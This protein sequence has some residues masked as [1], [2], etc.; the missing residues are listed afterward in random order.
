MKKTTKNQPP[1]AGRDRRKVFFCLVLFFVSLFLF[2]HQC[3]PLK[4]FEFT[5]VMLVAIALHRCVGLFVSF[6]AALL[7]LCFGDFARRPRD[8]AAARCCCW[9]TDRHSPPAASRSHSQHQLQTRTHTH[10]HAHTSAP[11]PCSA[12]LPAATRTTS[13]RIKSTRAPHQP[14]AAAASRPHAA[15]IPAQLAHCTQRATGKRPLIADCRHSCTRQVVTR[16]HRHEPT[17]HNG[18]AVGVAPAV[19]PLPAVRPAE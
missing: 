11:R 16:D 4:R 8:L 1:W 6:S 2:V 9:L 14:T 12:A 5:T 13:E 7:F 17:P 18:L 10:T 15:A 19:Q 3:T